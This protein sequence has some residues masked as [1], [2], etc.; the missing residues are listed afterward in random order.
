MPAKTIIYGMPSCDTTAKGIA[1]LEENKIDYEFHNY[2][3]SGIDEPSLRTMLTLL[4]KTEVVTPK[5]LLFKKLG[6]AV[7]DQILADD[8]FAV[9]QLMANPYMIKR[10]IVVRDNVALSGFNQQK[11]AETLL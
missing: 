9:E 8:A 1:F 4:E 3:K 2:K 7:Q 11:W 6:K 10:P 5:G